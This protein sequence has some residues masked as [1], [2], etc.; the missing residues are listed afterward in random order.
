VQQVH[1]AL[2]IG[3]RRVG[4]LLDRRGQRRPLALVILLHM[5]DRTTWSRARPRRYWEWLTDLL[6]A[7]DRR[8]RTTLDGLQSGRSIRDIWS[9]AD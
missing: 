1:G 7:S 4:G 2:V 8:R 5:H 6:Q 9:T 3:Q